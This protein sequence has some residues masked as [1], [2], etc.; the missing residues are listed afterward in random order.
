MD[1]DNRIKPIRVDPTGQQNRPRQSGGAHAQGTNRQAGQPRGGMPP[2]KKNDTALVALISAAVVLVVII[3]AVVGGGA[4][5]AGRRTIFPN[6][7]VAGVDVGGMTVDGAAAALMG[8][9]IGVPS[10]VQAT[11]V[12]TGTESVSVTSDE[13]GL[14]VSATQAAEMAYSF[15]RE[16]SFF[17]NLGSFISCATAPHEVFSARTVNEDGVRAI[18]AQAAARANHPAA[19]PKFEVTNTELFITRGT[20]GYTVDENGVFKYIRDTLLSGVSGTTEEFS[21]AKTAAAPASEPDV[22]AIYDAVFTEPKDAYFDGTT[23][24]VNAAVKG[25][26]FDKD[27]A[28]R[29]LEL[30][31]VG[32][33]VR[34]PLILT[35]PA[36]SSENVEDLLFRDKLAE[37]ST[38]LRTSTA[39]RITN[40]TLAAAAIN[41]TVL[42]PG[43]EFSYNDVVGERTAAK[44]YK[45]AGAYVGGK[46]VDSI[47]G[48]ICQVSSTIYYCTLLADLEITQ[49][50]NHGYTVAYLPLGLDA[51]VSWPNLNF[52]F[53]NDKNFP[54]KIVAW[55]ENKELYV[56]LWGTK[57]NDYRVELESNI[58]KTVPYET[59]EQVDESLAPGEKKVD[60]AGQTGYVSEAYKLIYD[61]EGNLLSRTLLSKDTYKPM[62][63]IVLVGPEPSEPAEGEG[64]GEESGEGTGEGQLPPDTQEPGEGEDPSGTVDPGEEPGEAEEPGDTGNPGE[65]DT[66][67]E[68]ENTGDD[69]G[70]S[71]DEENP[72]ED[73][74]DTVDIAG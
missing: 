50:T 57:E 23:G 49:R 17:S 19:E 61:G 31:G 65:G 20:G 16:G 66:P 18:I 48:G 32:E 4:Y 59:V 33:T 11:A 35:D 55:V 46:H 21:E 67:T 6:V 10:G 74:S 37:K 2:K 29:L 24:T 56:E 70:A 22:D 63:K 52:K 44:G 69:T 26:S 15:G 13:A 60:N 68:G 25:V 8:S 7:T 27:E 41:G 1:E 73:D 47:G 51:T 58:I 64:T 72:D 71:G 42:N 3:A 53:R 39:N 43:D 40:V 28:R 12:L 9:N 34:V 36:N 14:A 5:V 62:T 45:P 54:V 30:A 38:T